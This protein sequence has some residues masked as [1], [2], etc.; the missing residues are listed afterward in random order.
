[1]RSVLSEDTIYER[2]VNKRGSSSSEDVNQ[3][4]LSDESLE[5]GLNNLNVTLNEFVGD[6]VHKYD[7][8]SESSEP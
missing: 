8:H 1:M 3:Q 5:V 6:P 7:R 2:A 4:D